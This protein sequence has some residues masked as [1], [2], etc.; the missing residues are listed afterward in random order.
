ME[1][2]KQNEPK[3][4]PIL[5]KGVEV[6]TYLNDMAKVVEGNKDGVLKKIITEQ[7]KYEERKYS[8]SPKAKTNRKL[9]IL[10]SFFFLAAIAVLAVFLIHKKENSTVDVQVQFQPP[11][12]IDTSRFIEINGLDKS[13]I[14]NSVLSEVNKSKL[15]QGDVIG[16]YF[17]ENK[18]VVGLRKFLDLIKA[19]FIPGDE[20]FVKENFLVGVSNRETKDFFMLIK[21]RSL[22][23][24]FKN[25]R[26]WESKI[27][28]DLHEF[29]GIKISANTEY[30]LTKD[31]EDGIVKNK[32][33][34]ILYDNERK[35]VLMYVYVDDNSVVLTN[36]ESTAE[37]I[38]LRLMPGQIKK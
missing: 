30:L 2:E 34:R 36:T 1:E 4:D 5:P 32:N 7:E 17:V 24:V 23:D 20:L 6:E 28:Y 31:F 22:M 33:A 3:S 16:V 13:A 11:F 18:K 10:G 26:D 14:A 27:F 35:I 19:S 38:M 25:M 12:F 9:M 8:E 15:K 21:M 37:E 29:F